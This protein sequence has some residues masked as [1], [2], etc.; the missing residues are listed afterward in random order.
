M[1]TSS[2][3]PRSTLRRSIRDVYRGR[4]RG[5]SNLWLVY[6]VKTDRDWI[7]PSDRQLVHWLYFLESEPTVTTF[8]L[9]PEPVVSTDDKE[10]RGAELDAIAVYRDGH[11]EWHEIKAGTR[12][13]PTD[14]SQFLAQAAAATKEGV[15][16]TVFNDQDLRPIAAVALRWIK[17]LSFAA[18][19]R[20]QEQ[21]PCRTALAAYF[22]EHQEGTIK[23]VV[24]DLS[25]FDQPVVLGM[26]VRMAVG[27]V[28]RFD[29]TRRSFGLRTSWSLN[30]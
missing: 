20:G 15:K 25:Q 18:V 5:N 28:I 10:T 2:Q 9:A 8:D 27:N 11:L 26:M 4:G 24:T 13:N 21:T 17:P 23:A 16:Y 29:M 30:G 7:L 6:S 22:R 12:T 14:R 3:S 19:L 1:S